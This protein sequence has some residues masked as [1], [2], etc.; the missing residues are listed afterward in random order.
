LLELVAKKNALW[1]E[2]GNVDQLTDR[3][4]LLLSSLEVREL[5]GK[6]AQ[7]RASRYTL[8]ACADRLAQAL[9]DA[10][11]SRTLATPAVEREEKAAE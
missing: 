7:L 3:V 2:L 4:S 9:R 5:L 6:R 11:A 8:R 1:F 10:V